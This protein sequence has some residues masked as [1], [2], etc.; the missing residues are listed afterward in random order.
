M[1]HVISLSLSI[2]SEDLYKEVIQRL[3]KKQLSSSHRELLEKIQRRLSHEGKIKEENGR[4]HLNS[5][6]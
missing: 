6:S 3:G 1:I 5:P 2:T 4:L